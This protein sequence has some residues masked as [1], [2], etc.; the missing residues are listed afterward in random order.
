MK[1]RNHTHH[2]RVSSHAVERFAER[3]FNQ[4]KPDPWHQYELINEIR[5]LNNTMKREL[6]SYSISLPLYPRVY[7]VIKDNIVVTILTDGTGKFEHNYKKIVQHL[8]KCNSAK[9]HK[10]SAAA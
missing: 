2:I 8:K 7:A 1:N 9:H 4:S 10:Y 5:S 6:H 3:V